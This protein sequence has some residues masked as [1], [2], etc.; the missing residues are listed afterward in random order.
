M[1]HLQH[2]PKH[3]VHVTTYSD[4]QR[5]VYA[6]ARGD[7]NLLILIGGPG[8]EKSRL[9]HDAVGPQACW[10][11]GHATALG[12]FIKLFRHRDELAIIDDVDSLYSDRCAVRLL[13]ALC[14]TDSRKRLAWH[15]Q[16]ATLEREAVPHEFVTTTRVAI[17]ANEWS[18]LNENVKAIEDRGHVLVFEP[19]ALEVHR[20]VTEWF[21]DQEIF[22]F[23]ASNLHLI[24][25]PSMR[26]YVKAAELKKASLAWRASLLERW[27]LTETRLLVAMLLA[28][29]SFTTEQ[30]RVDAF[31]R[32]SGKCAATFYNHA[33]HL[34]R[35]IDV[36]K[37]QL[38]N[39][40]PEPQAPDADILSIL[41]RR[42]G[43]LGN[44]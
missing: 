26:D 34:R 19:T 18:T 32:A 1:R 38:S 33:K 39:L 24:S 14:Q 21:R 43:R 8:L 2:Y 12:M 31:T 23:V 37:L 6:F 16:T 22:D 20:R 7:L 25:S 29:E 17:I 3:A 35:T 13:K 11:E 30:E 42:H 27:G 36:P 15:S 9:M 4:L 40:P 41:R 10:I 28:D 44:G 5:W